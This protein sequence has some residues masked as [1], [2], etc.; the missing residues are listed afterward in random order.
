MLRSEVF[1][2]LWNDDQGFDS[3]LRAFDASLARLATDYM[4]VFDFALDAQ[5]MQAIAAMDVG[6]R[7]GPDPALS[8]ERAASVRG[9]FPQS[10]SG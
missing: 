7:I 3:T 9:T 8:A 5:D 10:R 2:K 1:T 4:V 6:H